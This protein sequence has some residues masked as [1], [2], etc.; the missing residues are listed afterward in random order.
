MKTLSFIVAGNPDD[1]HGNPIPKLKMTG[2]QSWTPR[3]R[4]YVAWK[5]MI[6]AA[7]LDALCISEHANSHIERRV[8]Q[9]L[10]PLDIGIERAHMDI[11]CTWQ[12]DAHPDAENV[13]GSIADALFHNDKKLSGSFNFSDEVK[14]G[15]VTIVLTLPDGAIDGTCRQ[16]PNA[17]KK[18]T[19]P[20]KT[21][22]SGPKSHLFS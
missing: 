16:P 13:F 18:R 7:F 21:S 3:A 14:L 12:N 10:K 9:G 17:G 19:T 22:Q 6:R 4:R 15:S 2:R 20:K 5:G 11:F 8:A 1:P